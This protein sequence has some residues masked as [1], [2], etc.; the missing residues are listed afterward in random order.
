MALGT[1]LYTWMQLTLPKSVSPPPLVLWS[2]GGVAEGKGS[3]WS[4]VTEQSALPIAKDA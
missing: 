4:W 3:L 1:V 2:I